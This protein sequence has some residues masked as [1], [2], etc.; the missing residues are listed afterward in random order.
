MSSLINVC[1]FLILIIILF[2]GFYLI[3]YFNITPADLSPYKDFKY[4]IEPSVRKQAKADYN[5][6]L[7]RIFFILNSKLITLDSSSSS[8]SSKFIKNLN[9]ELKPTLNEISKNYTTDQKG[10]IIKYFIIK[11][12]NVLLDNY[13]TGPYIY[14]N[15]PD[16]PEFGIRAFPFTY[17][18]KSNRNTRSKVV[19]G[20]KLAPFKYFA[21]NIPTEIRSKVESFYDYLLI[22]YTKILNSA[23][24][25]LDEVN[26][27]TIMS[28]NINSILKQNFLVIQYDLLKIQ[29]KFGNNISDLIKS[30]LM[31]NVLPLLNKYY[32]GPSINLKI[33]ADI[34]A[35]PHLVSINFPNTDNTHIFKVAQGCLDGEEIKTVNNGPFGYINQC[36]SKK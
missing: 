29:R 13:Y 36:V 6:I 19:K 1:I 35:M 12:V 8:K 20:S 32:T 34:P 27:K 16:M 7:N 26:N 24:A 28:I 21:H 23:V 31:V 17:K 10:K 2:I 11:H 18:P 22:K 4:A 15:I 14:L 5:I 3:R 33:H 30:I 25:N 9:K